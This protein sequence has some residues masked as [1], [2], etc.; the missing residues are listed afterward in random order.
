[1]CCEGSAYADPR[2]VPRLGGTCLNVGCI[3]SK[4]LL[5]T[6]HM[7][8]EAGHDFAEQGIVVGAPQIDVAKMMARKSA[9]VSQLTGGIVGLF[10][11]NKVTLLK[12]YGAFAARTEAGWQV[13]VGD[14]LVAAGQVIIA[15]GSKARAL[16]G[17]TIDNKLVCDNEGALDFASVPK[18]LVII[19]AGVVGLELGSVWRRLG[20][21]VTI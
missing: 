5:H 2:G 1:A 12:G 11:K 20:S 14:E 4:A 7:F 15:T 13:K 9:I 10:K 18:K 16:P 8:E 6:S 3:P 21:E 19:G 17:V